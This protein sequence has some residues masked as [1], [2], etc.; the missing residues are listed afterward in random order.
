MGLPGAGKTVLARP[1]PRAA[2]DG[3]AVSARRAGP[4]A[5]DAR[6]APGASPGPTATS[7]CVHGLGSGSAASRNG[8]FV[9]AAVPPYRDAWAGAARTPGASCT[10]TP[11]WTLCAARDRTGLYRRAFA[12]EIAHFTGVNDPYEA[13]ERPELRVTPDLTDDA[14]VEAVIAALHAAAALPS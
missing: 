9:V 5:L 10:S 1:S 12:G 6:A 7:T 13:P 14:R 2:G 4:R 11:R 8:V 3:A